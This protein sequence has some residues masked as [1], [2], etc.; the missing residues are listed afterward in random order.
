MLPHD[1]ASASSPCPTNDSPSGVQPFSHKCACALPRTTQANSSS[2]RRA[3]H[4]Q[5][6]AS[7]FPFFIDMPKF[8]HIKRKTAP[9]GPGPGR[10]RKP[11]LEKAAPRMS[12]D[13]LAR[14]LWS[15]SYEELF[16][17]AQRPPRGR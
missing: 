9:D 8:T 16:N 15:S 14:L 10:P 11:P 3:Q 4:Q 5:L 2:E 17:L 6:G 1:S 7:A 13:E 12:H